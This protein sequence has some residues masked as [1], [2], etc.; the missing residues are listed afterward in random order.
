VITASAPLPDTRDIVVIGA[1]A[2]GI[3]AARRLAGTGLSVCVLEAR[4]RVG[5][6]AHTLDHRLVAHRQGSV[7]VGLDMG[8]GWLHSADENVLAT[9]GR[10][11][12]FTID[13]TPPPWGQ[14]TFNMG[15]DA[16][17]LTD[18]RR[19]FDA[20]DDR[21]AKVA[22]E[23][24]D[25]AA[26]TLLAP[27]DDPDSRWNARIDAVMGAINAANCAHL[28]ILDYD[29]YRDTGVNHRV[30]EGYG[31]MVAAQAR[32]L[33][34]VLDCPVT[35]IDRS[36]P[37]LRVETPRGVVV[38][39]AAI[40]TVPTD[41]IG[42][43]TIRIDP[44]VPSL[45]EAAQGV[46]LGLASKVHMTVETPDDFPADSQVWGRTDTAQTAGYHLRPFARPM[47]EAYFGGDLAW[48]LEAEG[49]PAF[50][51]FAA[52][53]LSNLLGSSFRKRIAPVATSMWGAEPWSRGAYSH[54]L[55]GHSGDRA[56]LTQPVEDRIFVAGEA[57]APEFYG[58]AHG[59]WME[60]ERAAV[61]ALTALG[62]DPRETG[63]YDEG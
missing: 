57:T 37:E 25:D 20:F 32:G 63:G 16:K 44:P 58:T 59:A 40:L 36:D 30:R 12:G 4:D 21:I 39:R 54:C 62:V 2:A 9:L 26:S 56:I 41:L 15:L 6:R 51:D 17:E 50:F 42:R 38:C 52:S 29:A 43:E 45:I 55:P 61:E 34:V 10:Q 5:G 48:G 46:P 11:T 49:E 47:I 22:A 27:S 3:A 14:A 19:A 33:P 23:N 53:E 18:F 60:G 24:R 28:S 7:E 13:E 8:C 35:R 1:G 31:R